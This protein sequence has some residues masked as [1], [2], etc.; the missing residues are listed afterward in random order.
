MSSTMPV[1]SDADTTD[2]QQLL[3]WRH[4]LLAWYDAHRRDLPWRRTSDPYSIWL[5]EIMLQQTRVAAVIEKYGQFLKSFPTVAALA[6]AAE[7]DVL[8]R[9][10]GLGYYRRARMLHQA[11]QFVMQEL[12]GA[13]PGTAIGLRAL[14]GVGVYTAAA[15]ASIAYGEAIAVV[16]GNVERVVQRLQGWGTESRSGKA[17]LLRA[18]HRFA[19][20]LLDPERAGDFNQAMMELGATVCLPKGPLCLTCPLREGCR[21]QGEHPTVKR[22]RMSSRDAGYALIVRSAV[23]GRKGRE[24]LLDQRSPDE[25]VMQGMWELP[26]LKSVEVPEEVLRMSVRHAIMQVNYYVRVRTVFEDDADAL[27]VP[28]QGRKWVELQKVGELPLTG[29]ARKILLRA[30]LA[31][32]AAVVER[33]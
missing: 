6:R 11:A 30:G 22:A 19:N 29:L 9:W 18:T 32:L 21:T 13:I 33:G 16:D 1:G 25:T 24:V 27:T 14:P 23:A 26:T 2:S 20:A 10:S 12:E 4:R 28:S 17:A 15:I 5:S 31:E 7:P 8:A 3:D